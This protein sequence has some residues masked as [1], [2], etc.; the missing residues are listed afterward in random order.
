M[1]AM[2]CEK[3]VPL[4]DDEAEE[5]KVIEDLQRRVQFLPEEQLIDLETLALW[6]A[7]W[8]NADAEHERAKRFL[9]LAR[10]CQNELAVSSQEQLKGSY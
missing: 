10:A 6:C 3:L 1:D 9:A 2:R 5:K 8:L 7:Q 4:S